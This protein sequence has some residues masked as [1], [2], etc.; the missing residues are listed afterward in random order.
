MTDR[1]EIIR[2]INTLTKAG[3][4]VVPPDGEMLKVGVP[5][6]TVVSLL[7]G[8]NKCVVCDTPIEITFLGNTINP[9]TSG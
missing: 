7:E 5:K 6:Y 4:V 2:A 3:Y 1:D 8:S 9:K